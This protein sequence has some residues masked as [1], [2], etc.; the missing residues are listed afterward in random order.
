MGFLLQYQI[1]AAGFAEAP[2]VPLIQSGDNLLYRSRHVLGTPLLAAVNG[3]G[4]FKRDHIA[5]PIGALPAGRHQRF[6]GKRSAND[7]K[8]TLLCSRY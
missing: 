6:L 5:I 1:D 3:V 2:Q 4:A 7:P 8:R